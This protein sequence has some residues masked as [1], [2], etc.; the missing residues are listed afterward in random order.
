MI[1]PCVLAPFHSSDSLTCLSQPTCTLSLYRTSR[2][3][4]S[5]YENGSSAP[6]KRVTRHASSSARKLGLLTLNPRL[7][8][9]YRRAIANEQ[10]THRHF[11]PAHR[12]SSKRNR[13]NKQDVEPSILPGQSSVPAAEVRIHLT[14]TTCST[15]SVHRRIG[16]K[17]SHPHPL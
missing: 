9:H 15:A 2:A 13:T 3:H 17:S 16:R 12:K 14:F 8:L 1:F 11:E 5:C 7:R 6:R 4:S 10:R